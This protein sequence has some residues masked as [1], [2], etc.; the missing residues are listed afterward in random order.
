MSHHRK[1]LH[2]GHGGHS[3]HDKDGWCEGIA[4]LKADDKV[5]DRGGRPEGSD[6]TAR[7]LHGP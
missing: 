1:G 6:G 3:H 7:H 2:H 5:S 4:S